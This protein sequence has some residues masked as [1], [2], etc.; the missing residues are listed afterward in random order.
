MN[1]QYFLANLAAIG[2]SLFS[3][4]PVLAECSAGQTDVTIVNPAGKIIEL[5]IPDAAVP[6]IEAG[7]PGA[8]IPATCPCFSPQDV[9]NADA[10]TPL[11]CNSFNGL[12]STSLSCS[13]EICRPDPEDE[14]YIAI[15]IQD[16][17]PSNYSG[18]EWCYVDNAPVFP[19]SIACKA[20]GE[21]GLS[22]GVDGLTLEE[23]HAC[24]AILENYY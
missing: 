22:Y 1:K 15:T 4:Q 10:E 3:S 23:A 11:T 6:A 16:S 2:I 7:N 9:E 21:N 19:F 20:P 24:L 13:G 12:T 17:L 18:D 8:V 5:C 14:G